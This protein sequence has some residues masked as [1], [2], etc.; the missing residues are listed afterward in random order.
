MRKMQVGVLKAEKLTRG[1]SII[2]KRSRQ[3]L[4]W[5]WWMNHTAVGRRV[6]LWGC[7]NEQ[8]NSFT[9]NFCTDI[10]SRFILTQFKRSLTENQ[11][12]DKHSKLTFTIF[13]Y[14][15]LKTELVYSHVTVKIVDS[16]ILDAENLIKD[17][18]MKISEQTGRGNSPRD[19]TRSRF[20]ARF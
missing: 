18:L 4:R 15:H 12:I 17:W 7:K 1:W 14:V 20:W 10:L 3:R 13:R 5:R 8:L 16:V 2:S 6:G 19:W 9:V 11:D